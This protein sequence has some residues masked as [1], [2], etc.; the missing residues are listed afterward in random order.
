M[1]GIKFIK[2]RG[3]QLGERFVDEGYAVTAETRIPL[4]PSMLPSTQA[5]LYGP[6][7]P[8]KYPIQRIQ[9]EEGEIGWWLDNAAAGQLPA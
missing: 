3:Y 6:H 1:F 7:Q 8:E 5:A 4:L 2:V 9:P